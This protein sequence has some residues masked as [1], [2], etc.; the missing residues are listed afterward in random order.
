VLNRLV[1][2]ISSFFALI[3]H[4]SASDSPLPHQHYRFNEMF[5]RGLEAMEAGNPIEASTRLAHLLLEEQTERIWLEYGRALFLSD[6][7]YEADKVFSHILAKY[8]NL[9]A[10][11]AQNVAT[12]QEKIKNQKFN[13]SPEFSLG[14]DDN[15]YNIT[16][17]RT[18]YLFGGLPFRYSV[19]PDQNRGRPYQELGLRADGRFSDYLKW[20]ARSSS[21]DYPN[22]PLDRKTNALTFTNH[23][24]STDDVRLSPSLSIQRIDDHLGSSRWSIQRVIATQIRP[25]ARQSAVLDVYKSRTFYDGVGRYDSSLTGYGTSMMSRNMDGTYA[26]RIDHQKNRSLKDSES[27]EDI[28]AQLAYQTSFVLGQIGFESGWSYKKFEG[29]Q[30][31]FYVDRADRERSLSLSVVLPPSNFI[32]HPISIEFGKIRR[33]STINYY[34]SDQTMVS[35]GFDF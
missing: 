7:P 10:P 18:V 26:M 11:V 33:A 3:S 20:Q 32:V 31:P 19:D 9:P 16:D 2:G 27:Y 4:L 12:F 35:L 29:D 8:P 21:K 14:Y 6:K 1:L 17:A 24:L 25:Y 13:I 22:K 34:S 5:T 28:R 30:A 15:P 23:L